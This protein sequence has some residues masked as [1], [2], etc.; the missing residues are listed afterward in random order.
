[1]PEV[2]ERKLQVK[3]VLFGS[4][5]KGGYFRAFESV[6]HPGIAGT[7]DCPKRGAPEVKTFFFQDKEYTSVKD[8]LEAWD[9]HEVH[10]Q[11]EGTFQI[12]ERTE[13]GDHTMP[14][15]CNPMPLVESEG[16]GEP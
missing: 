11:R 14:F 8:V 12:G 1:M 3:Y 9:R 2:N 13:P 4:K 15:K 16:E 10:K 6:S 7:I 5:A